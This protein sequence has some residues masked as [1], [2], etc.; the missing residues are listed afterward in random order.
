MVNIQ[1]ADLSIGNE[2]VP[3]NNEQIKISGLL[4]M[5]HSL[6]HNFVHVHTKMPLNPGKSIFRYS[7][8]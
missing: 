8:Y 7:Q 3:N 6:S 4:E 2:Y 5:H 1:D